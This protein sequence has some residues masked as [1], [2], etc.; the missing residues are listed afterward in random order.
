M[1]APQDT[2]RAPRPRRS[3]FF[4]TLTGRQVVP[5]MSRTHAPLRCRR[6]QHEEAEE[7]AGLGKL[8]DGF[9]FGFEDNDGHDYFWRAPSR[10]P[11]VDGHHV[12]QDYFPWYRSSEAPAP[13][14]AQHQPWKPI[15][16]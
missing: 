10:K 8:G 2:L 9:D 16:R 14:D 3:G 13:A 12:A 1:Q 6:Q 7:E 11:H 4:D 15:E 5:P